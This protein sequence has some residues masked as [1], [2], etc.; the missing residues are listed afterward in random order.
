MRAQRFQRHTNRFTKMM[1]SRVHARHTTIISYGERK[2][3]R[4]RRGDNLQQAFNGLGNIVVIDQPDDG[5]YLLPIACE[6]HAG[7]QA[8]DSAEFI[9]D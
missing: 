1:E 7:G 8:Q 9:R 5:S 4:L 3:A 6:E 2:Q